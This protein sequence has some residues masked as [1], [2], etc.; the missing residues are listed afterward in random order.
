[1]SRRKG[2]KLNLGC[3][4]EFALGGTS[5]FLWH[6]T[7]LSVGF[8]TTRPDIYVLCPLKLK[9][10]DVINS[11]LITT[12]RHQRH[13]RILHRR[14]LIRLGI[15]LLFSLP[16]RDSIEM[17]HQPP[18]T[19]NNPNRFLQSLYL[20]RLTLLLSLRPNKKKERK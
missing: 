20:F 1:M 9:T 12:E 17:K 19:P 4:S 15:N 14:N 13:G 6:R 5:E 8:S 7:Q 3:A 2:G 11:N 16:P 18:I 10:H